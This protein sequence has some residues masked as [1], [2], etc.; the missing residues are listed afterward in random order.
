MNALA[1]AFFFIACRHKDRDG[2]IIDRFYVGM[3]AMKENNIAQDDDQNH[4]LKKDKAQNY[5]VNE[6][7]SHILSALGSEALGQ[8]GTQ[9]WFLH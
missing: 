6:I 7:I 9:G 2:W 5:P 4:Y 3:N 8:P 1:D